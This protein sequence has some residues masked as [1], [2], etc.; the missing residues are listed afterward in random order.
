[1]IQTYKVQ[2]CPNNKQQTKLFQTAGTARFAYN[3]ALAYEKQ[4]HQND[5]KFI[6][7]IDLRKIFTSVKKQSEFEWLN[8][9]SND[10]MK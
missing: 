4:N 1:M 10:V 9:Y 5:G 2:L 3:W 6:S 8:Q 7:D